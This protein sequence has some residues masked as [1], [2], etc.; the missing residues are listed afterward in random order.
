MDPRLLCVGFGSF[1]AR[2]Q[3]F[4]V[5]CFSDYECLV[6]ACINCLLQWTGILGDLN[7]SFVISYDAET[8]MFNPRDP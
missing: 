3:H 7:L 1:A 5:R 2:G 6:Q 4:T 8:G